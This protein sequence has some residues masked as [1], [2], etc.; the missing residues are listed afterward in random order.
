MG[1]D[2][3]VAAVK[4]DDPAFLGDVQFPDFPFVFGAGHKRKALA[5]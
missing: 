4:A 2:E 1:D 5:S 3:I